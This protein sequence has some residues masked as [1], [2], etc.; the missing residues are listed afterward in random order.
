MPSDL[1]DAPRNESKDLVNEV[2]EL[3]PQG[4]E[5]KLVSLKRRTNLLCKVLESDEDEK[6]KSRQNRRPPPPPQS[7]VVYQIRNDWSVLGNPP[8]WYELTAKRLHTTQLCT[9]CSA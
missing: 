9:G 3:Y 8:S 1:K 2:E 7:E 6:W 5:H 4:N